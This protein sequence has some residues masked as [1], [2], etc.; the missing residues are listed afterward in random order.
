MLLFLSPNQSNITAGIA[1]ASVVDHRSHRHSA[2]MLG[3]IFPAYF[4]GFFAQLFL[5][6]LTI[7]L[8]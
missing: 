2:M 6:N 3:V 8:K 7:L 4:D 1:I 5:C